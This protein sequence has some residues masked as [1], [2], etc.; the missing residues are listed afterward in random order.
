VRE[1]AGALQLR[2]D[3]ALITYRIQRMKKN[4]QETFPASPQIHLSSQMCFIITRMCTFCISVTHGMLFS[5]ITLHKG[6][7]QNVSADLVILQFTC[8]TL[9]DEPNV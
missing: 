7:S 5:P 1:M 3:S 2:N 9:A 4:K 6:C 8:M